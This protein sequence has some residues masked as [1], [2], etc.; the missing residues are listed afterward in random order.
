V[1]PPCKNLII[2]GGDE[3]KRFTEKTSQ[4][5]LDILSKIINQKLLAMPKE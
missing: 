1:L 4:E 5:F 3:G 2:G